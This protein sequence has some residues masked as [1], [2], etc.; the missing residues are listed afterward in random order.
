MIK[1][2][3][4]LIIT[5][6]FLTLLVGCI[7]RQ[8]NYFIEGVF[9]NDE[10]KLVITVVDYETFKNSGGKNVVKDESFK[11][12][13]QYFEILLYKIDNEKELELIFDDLTFKT[14][15]TAEPC[16][17]SDKNGNG[18]SPHTNQ[19]RIGY[20]IVYNNEIINLGG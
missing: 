14:V 11:R 15:T 1:R 5:F 3:L 2:I 18:I 17:Y 6:L 4:K 12:K 7:N 20:R 13:N 10:Y 9:S 19:Q 8:S 16:F